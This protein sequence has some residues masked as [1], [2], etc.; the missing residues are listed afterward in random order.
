MWLAHYSFHLLTS[1]D[2]IIPT[3][4]RFIVDRGWSFLG[5]PLWQRACCRPAGEWIPHLEILM[6]DCG[7]LLSLYTALRIAEANSTRTARALKTFAPWAL[8]I[9]L[10]FA[11]GVWIVYQPMQMRGTLSA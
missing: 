9:G 10:M 5:Q 2:T 6:L 1:C 3:T 4:Q 11:A 7:V 8:L